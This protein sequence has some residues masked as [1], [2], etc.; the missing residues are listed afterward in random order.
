VRPDVEGEARRAG[1]RFAL[2]EQPLEEQVERLQPLVRS[3]R[4]VA[5]EAHDVEDGVGR[6]RAVQPVGELGLADGVAAALDRRLEDHL[7]GRSALRVGQ[8]LVALEVIRREVG[9]EGIP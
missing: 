6:F 9:E 7:D 2:L 5:A 8:R 3:R 4:L 1:L